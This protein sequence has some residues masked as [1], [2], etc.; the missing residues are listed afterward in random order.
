MSKDY[1]CHFGVAKASI[2]EVNK[3]ATTT[4]PAMTVLDPIKRAYEQPRE[5]IGQLPNYTVA[6]DCSNTYSHVPAVATQQGSNAITTETTSSWDREQRQQQTTQRPPQTNGTIQLDDN[7]IPTTIERAAAE[8]K[9]MAAQ[10]SNIS[11]VAQNMPNL[12]FDKWHYRLPNGDVRGPYQ[13]D[14][15]RQW[16]RRNYFQRNLPIKLD[17]YKGFYPLKA[18]FPDEKAAFTKEPIHPQNELP[19]SKSDLLQQVYEQRGYIP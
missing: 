15:M 5:V 16:Q 9:A 19:M 8:Q 2:T 18:L 1:C 12:P 4:T 3:A 7:T 14:R 6:Q 10:G 11:S 17:W 13:L